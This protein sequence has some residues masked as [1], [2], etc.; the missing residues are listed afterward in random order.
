MSDFLDKGLRYL[1]NN[2]KNTFLINV[3][4]MDGYRYDELIGYTELFNFKGLYVEPI[5]YLFERL[6]NNFKNKDGNLFEN[7]AISDFEGNIEMMMIEQ[8][9][10]DDGY[11]NPCFYGMSAVYPPKNG[12]S[13]EGDREIVEK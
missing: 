7:V 11:V 4:A 13:S 3:G 10:I 6:K 9:A 8:S 1:G 2:K 12:L 5:P